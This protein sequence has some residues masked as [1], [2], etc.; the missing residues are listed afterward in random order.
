MNDAPT[1]AKRTKVVRRHDVLYGKEVRYVPLVMQ[2]VEHSDTMG[3]ADRS[4]GL[5]KRGFPYRNIIRY[6]LL[7]R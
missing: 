1:E 4:H 6:F 2:A 3:R 5:N 7:F